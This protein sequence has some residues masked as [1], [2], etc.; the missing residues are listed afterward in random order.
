MLHS[1]IRMAAL[2]LGERWALTGNLLFF[3]YAKKSVVSP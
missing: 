1:Q 3:F 2:L